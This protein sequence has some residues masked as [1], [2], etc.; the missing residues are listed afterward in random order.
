MY[1]VYNGLTF[2]GVFEAT[3]H[4]ILD[5]LYNSE[6]AYNTNTPKAVFKEWSHFLG[7]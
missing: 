1:R 5:G 7:G 4:R 6:S 2:L 3:S